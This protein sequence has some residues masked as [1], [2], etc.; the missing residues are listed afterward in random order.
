M[1]NYEKQ[2]QDFLK[3]TKTTMDIKYLEHAKY[4][5]GDTQARDIY[6]VTLR[7]HGNEY[8]FKFGQSIH[9]TKQKKTPTAYDILA[10]LIGD[11]VDSFEDFCDNYGYNP[12]SISAHGIYLKVLDEWNNVNKLF[13]DVLE[14]LREIE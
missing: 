4:F 6:Q 2:A 13:G 10:C 14:E 12:D 3:R 8:I 7:R 1:T 9:D 5:P 11:E